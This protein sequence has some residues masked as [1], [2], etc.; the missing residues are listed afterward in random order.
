MTALW[1]HQQFLAFVAVGTLAA[2]CSILVRYLANLVVP[3]EFAVAI[4]HVSGMLCAF[5]LNKLV[6]FSKTS[7]PTIVELG[8]FALVNMLS[9]VVAT[10]VGSIAFRLLL[11]A[12]GIE[13]YADWIAHLIGLGA[14][15]IPSYLAHRHYSFRPRRA[16]DS[17]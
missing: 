15:A 10:V 2:S 9:L 1:I 16:S 12:L 5:T 7:H 13:K 17:P 3:F 11:P 14:C 6:V 8:R 4:S